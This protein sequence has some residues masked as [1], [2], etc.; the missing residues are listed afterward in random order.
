MVALLQ[1]VLQ[2]YAA[3]ALVSQ[4]SG[5]ETDDQVLDTVLSSRETTWLHHIK[6]AADA[7][8]VNGNSFLTAVRRRMESIVLALPSGS[9][10]QRIQVGLPCQPP[11]MGKSGA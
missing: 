3:R 9:N 8:E 1:H 5:E 4:K 10:A 6:S 11:C 2:L 7:G